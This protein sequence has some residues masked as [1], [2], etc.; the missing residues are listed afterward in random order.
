MPETLKERFTRAIVMNGWKLFQQTQV[1]KYDVYTHPAKTHKL[2]VGKMGAVRAGKN[3][4]DC[5]PV[6]DY[7]KV[8]LLAKLAPYD[9]PVV[10]GKDDKE[11][12]EA[13]GWTINRMGGETAELTVMDRKKFLTSVALRTHV[14][15]QAA[16]GSPLHLRAVILCFPK[17]SKG[18]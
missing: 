8:S 1:R 6:S 5:V 17:S 14:L 13:E 11:Q 10:W 2:F 16:L 7:A 12:A 15:A 3:T 4:S 18:G 9:A